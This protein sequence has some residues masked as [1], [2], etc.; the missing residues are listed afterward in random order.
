MAWG[1]NIPSQ[2]AAV[3]AVKGRWGLDGGSARLVAC[4]VR[5]AWKWKTNLINLRKSYAMSPHGH[6]EIAQVMGKKKSGGYKPVQQETSEKGA[7][8]WK[9]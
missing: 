3:R 1:G 9:R 2:A 6:D 7:Q 8:M 5:Q 4:P